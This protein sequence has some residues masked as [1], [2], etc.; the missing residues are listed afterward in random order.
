MSVAD[1]RVGAASSVA[2]VRISRTMEPMECLR[3]KSLQATGGHV[4]P[5]PLKAFRDEEDVSPGRESWS[6]G[7]TGR[8]SLATVTTYISGRPVRGRVADQRGAHPEAHGPRAHG[9]SSARVP[10]LARRS[11]ERR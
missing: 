1:S 2:R 11:E 5:E 7:A 3:S 9:V 6:P 4:I 10:H 8:L